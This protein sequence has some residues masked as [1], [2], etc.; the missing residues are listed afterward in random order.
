MAR[1][2]IEIRIPYSDD[3]PL[4]LRPVLEQMGIPC[5]FAVENGSGALLVTIDEEQDA[6]L[7]CLWDWLTDLRVRYMEARQ[8]TMVEQLSLLPESEEAVIL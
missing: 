5:R 6:A 4:A 7:L 3:M 1:E 8:S 2:K